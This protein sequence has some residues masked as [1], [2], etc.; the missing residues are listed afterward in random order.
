MRTD[1]DDD[2]DVQQLLI[3]VTLN[4]LLLNLLYDDLLTAL[5]LIRLPGDS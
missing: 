1:D 2:D 5:R 3:P 4:F